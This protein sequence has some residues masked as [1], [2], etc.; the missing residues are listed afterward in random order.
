M[1]LIH[2]SVDSEGVTLGGDRGMRGVILD[3]R[4]VGERRGDFKLTKVLGG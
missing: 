1:I 2:R 4:G 3:S